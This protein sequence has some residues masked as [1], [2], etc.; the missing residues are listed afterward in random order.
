[1]MWN[2]S[3]VLA[4]LQANVPAWALLL[5]L[6][7]LSL[8]LIFA[9]S[10]LVKLVAFVVVGI[11]GAALGGTLVAQF[12][13]P[14]W[15]LLGVLMGFVIG[16]VL[17]VALIALG[18][19]LAAGYAAYVI[20]LDLALGQTVGI[21]AGVA[22]FVVGLAL[23]KKIL[24]VSTALVGGLLLFNVLTSYGFGSDIATLVAAALTIAG[25]WVQLTPQRRTAISTA[26]QPSN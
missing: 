14:G 22:F 19:G 11:A 23:S 8:V 24:T 13:S 4:P 18:M 17:G 2:I 21:I 12:V 16:G 9:G 26:A 5:G 3:G 1:M 15:Q 6:L 7:G 10:T 20:A 25:L